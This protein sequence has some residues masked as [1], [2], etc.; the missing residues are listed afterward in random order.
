MV[1]MP[2]P[3]HKDIY[4]ELLAEIQSGK[5]N[6]SRKLPSEGQLVKRF[7][8]SRPT[9]ARALRELQMNGLVTRKAGSGNYLNAPVRSAQEGLQLGLLVPELGSIEI[10]ESISSEFANMARIEQFGIIWG[11]GS[12]QSNSSQDL[13]ISQAE[14]T[15]ESL[16]RSAAHGVLFAPLEGGPNETAANLRITQRLSAANI[17]FVLLDRDLQPF[18]NRSNYDLV[19]M[20]NFR[21]GYLVAEHFVNLGVRKIAFFS[22]PHS[23]DTIDLRRAGIAAALASHA[24]PVDAPFAFEGDPLDNA[25]IQELV[26]EK[27]F[28]AIICANDKTA[29]QVLQTLNRLNL[30]VPKDIRIAG[31]DD[32]RLASLLPVPLTTVRQPC[33][34]LA[35]IAL[36]VLRGKIGSKGML[37]TPPLI[38]LA[39]PEL[40][41]RESSGSQL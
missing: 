19:T 24:V 29:A 40:V 13:T 17:P 26:K 6:Q 14:E 16:I 38:Y 2:S 3:K 32:F 10:F 30:T 39:T 34:D 15:C 33:R 27:R 12:Q 8:V 5:Y 4:A 20:D 25:L 28:E 35:R 31:F 23:A 1:Y 18:P 37:Q 41:V 22:R 36:Q 9:I 7:N 21:A 11:V